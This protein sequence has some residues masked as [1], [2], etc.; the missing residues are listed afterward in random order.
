MENLRTYPVVKKAAREGR[1]HVHAWFFEIGTAK[2]YAYN[3]DKGQYESFHLEE[4]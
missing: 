1:L 3:P 2:L 4:E